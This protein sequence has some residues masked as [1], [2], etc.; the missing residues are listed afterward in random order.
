[1]DM[2][3]SLDTIPLLISAP[4]RWTK[5]AIAGLSISL[6]LSFFLPVDENWVNKLMPIDGV[7]VV[8]FMKSATL[9]LSILGAWVASWIAASVAAAHQYCASEVDDEY[10]E[11]L[12][13]NLKPEINNPIRIVL[14]SATFEL[15]TSLLQT[16]RLRPLG[17][18]VL[19]ATNII[20]A[21]AGRT[22]SLLGLLSAA[23]PETATQSVDGRR[24]Y[25]RVKINMEDEEN[26]KDTIKRIARARGVRTT[27]K[28]IERVFESPRD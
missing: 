24:S 7:D 6:I 11:L 13:D 28:T 19:E 26:V 2:K 27:V 1:M 22:D 16:P 14:H 12:F 10:I 3:E 20:A 17:W 5:S 15:S 21:Q 25:A 9:G 18:V 4:A 8:M 23:L